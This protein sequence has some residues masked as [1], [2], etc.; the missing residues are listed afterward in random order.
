MCV[1]V[2]KG[3]LFLCLS[4]SIFQIYPFVYFFKIKIIILSILLFK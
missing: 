4:T 1:C 3:D 2:Y